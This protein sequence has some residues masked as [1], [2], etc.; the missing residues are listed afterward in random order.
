MPA[1]KVEGMSCQHCVN[2]ITKALKTLDANADVTINLDQKMV[3]VET[4]VKPEAIRQAIISEG[5]AVM[6]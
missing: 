5:Y 3:I 6:D 4:N 2:A 1:F